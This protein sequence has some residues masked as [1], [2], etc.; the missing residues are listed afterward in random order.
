MERMR[1]IVDRCAAAECLPGRGYGPVDQ[2]AL[3]VA[4]R[5]TGTRH[6]ADDRLDHGEAVETVILVFVRTRIVDHCKGIP[7]K[8]RG[9]SELDA[10]S[11]LQLERTSV[12]EGRSVSER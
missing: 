6:L 3:G 2:L 4:R 10:K 1:D 12:V 9:E 5:G 11:A 8:A 7:G